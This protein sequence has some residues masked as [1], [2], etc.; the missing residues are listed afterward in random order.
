MNKNLIFDV[1]MHKGEDTSYYLKK[2]FQVVAFEADP[3]LVSINKEKFSKEIK[4][5]DLIIVE[6]AIV[7][8]SKISTKTI[9]FYKNL[10]NSVWGTVVAKWSVRN[11]K[12]GAESK[13][14]DVPTVDF[15]KCIEVYGIPYYLKIDIE[16]MDV[17]CLESL[18]QFES[19][20]AYIS[21]ES[22]KVDFA[23]LIKE[24][25]LFEAFGYDNYQIINQEE[26]TLLKEPM[27]SREGKFLNYTFKKGSS[28]LFGS[29]YRNPWINKKTAL[30]NYKWIFF[31]YKIWGDH[32][33]IKY[34]FLMS[35]IKGI[36]MR[37]LKCK[38]PGWYDT[39]AR[40]SSIK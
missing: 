28:G 8:K 6:G 1:G 24:F 17:V 38:I 26:I 29:D 23:Q 37:L 9:K 11:E 14:I 7:D 16:G 20:P 36:L 4:N 30:R 15:V 19:K 2:G 33:R 13:I 32:S 40:H 27:D 5:G 25:E 35:R 3:D 39:H 21:I 10:S 34:W 22:E 12:M 18:V 31:G